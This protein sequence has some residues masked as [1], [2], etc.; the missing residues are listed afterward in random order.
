MTSKVSFGL[1]MHITYVCVY[2]PHPCCVNTVHTCGLHVNLHSH[3]ANVY[4]LGNYCVILQT[5]TRCF[6]QHLVKMTGGTWETLETRFQLPRSAALTQQGLE[7]GAERTVCGC[8]RL[9]ILEP[10]GDSATTF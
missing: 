9:H 10:T 6:C 2:E 5:T 3:G 1:H 4:T 8:P 7:P